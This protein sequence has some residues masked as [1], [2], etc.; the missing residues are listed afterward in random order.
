M[1]EKS[2]LPTTAAI[3]GVNRS[4]VSA[5]T[6]PPKAAPITTPTAIS[7][8]F[9]RRMNFLKPSSIGA[10]DKIGAKCM[11]G[12][13][14]GQVRRAAGQELKTTKDTKLHEG[15]FKVPPRSDPHRHHD[16]P[17]LVIITFSRPQLPCGLRIFQ[18]QPHFVGAGGFQEIDQVLGIEANREDL[19]V[20]RR[21]DGILGLTRFCRRCRNL[22]FA[23]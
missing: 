12:E 19:T 15:Y 21:F 7:T 4:F 10:S 13:R 5:V 22:Y 23:F 8:T 11:T 9:P 16:V 20:V 6:T 3:S 2:G 14:E 1:A 18:L 17:V